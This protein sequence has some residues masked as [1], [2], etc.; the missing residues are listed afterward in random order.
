MI[1]T[2]SVDVISGNLGQARVTDMTIA[3]CDEEHVGQVI[4]GAPNAFANSLNKAR[5]GDQVVGCNIGVIVTGNP[6][7]QIGEGGG[8]PAPYAIVD[9][10][11][12]KILYTEVDFGNLDDEQEINDGLNVYKP[13]GG[14][15]TKMEAA[16]SKALEVAPKTTVAQEATPA[17]QQAT[18]PT[19]CIDVPDPPPGNFQLS[20]NF[21]LSELSSN[22]AVS[23]YPVRAQQGLTVADIVCN[24]QA[25]AVSVGEVL[26]G[27]YGKTRLLV[28][29]GFRTGS[30]TSQHEKGQACDVQFP[31]KTNTEIYNI[32]LWVKTNVPYDQMILEYAGNRP[33]IHLSFNRAGNRP[34]S[35]SNK[36]GTCTSGATYVWGQLLNRA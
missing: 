27:Q 8:S 1:I 2:S 31:G 7:H 15:S 10:Q 30:S 26:C 18:P 16:R 19:Q 17:P 4:T 6:T 22:A 35:A 24:L 32:A 28:T 21:V 25:W 23:R 20:P 36:F 13:K 3:F 12:Q 33:W 14:A 34:A 29:S 5:I 9:F 11:G